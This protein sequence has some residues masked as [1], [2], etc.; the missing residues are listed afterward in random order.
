MISTILLTAAV[1]LLTILLA[2]PLGHYM[3]RV[4]EGQRFWATRLLG[5]LEN[6]IYRLT[7]IN[8]DDEMGWK[9]Y[10][11]SLFLFNL[12]GILFMYFIFQVQGGLP[13]VPSKSPDMTAGVLCRSFW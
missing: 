5:P 13:R 11:L 1:L 2:L 12:L 9:R 7:G 4:I 6:G 10:A 3:Y 8:T